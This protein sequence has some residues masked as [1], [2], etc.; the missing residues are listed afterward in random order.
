MIE[1]AARRPSPANSPSAVVSP[2]RV[3]SNRAGISGTKLDEDARDGGS[4][5]R[6]LFVTVMGEIPAAV[7]VWT[8]NVKFDVVAR[9]VN[10]D[11]WVAA[12]A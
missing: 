10:E 9:P 7:I 2:A 8:P 12:P 6:T 3:S 11:D 4:T 1:P 5:G